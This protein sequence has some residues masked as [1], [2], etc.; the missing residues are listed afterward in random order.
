[1]LT[2]KPFFFINNML[3][4]L[5]KI[6]DI[7]DEIILYEL[8]QLME[9]K[10]ISSMAIE[11]IANNIESVQTSDHNKMIKSTLISPIIIENGDMGDL[12]EQLTTMDSDS[13]RRLTD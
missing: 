9:R 7:E 4:R 8:Y 3:I 10:V 2:K 5:K 13:A 12:K 11:T 6:A 1:M